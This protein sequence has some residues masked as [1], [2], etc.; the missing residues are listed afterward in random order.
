MHLEHAATDTRRVGGPVAL[1]VLRGD[2]RDEDLAGPPD[3]H[4]APDGL[5]HRAPVPPGGSGPEPERLGRRDQV[6]EPHRVGQRLPGL[7]HERPDGEHDPSRA[8]PRPDRLGDLPGRG[9]AVVV[10]AGGSA[11]GDGAADE[12]ESAQVPG[13]ARAG[14]AHERDGHDPEAHHDRDRGEDAGDRAHGAVAGTAPH[15]PCI[16]ASPEPRPDPAEDD[17]IVYPLTLRKNP[18]DDR[19][20]C[21]TRTG[22]QAD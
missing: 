4:P 5:G 10:A 6:D 12:A 9:P 8:E 18:D 1:G 11:G 13:A 19:R 7:F 3:V 20:S 22:Q 17:P 2:R 16:D 15:R 21:V 14:G